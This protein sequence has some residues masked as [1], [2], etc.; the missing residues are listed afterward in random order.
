MSGTT[1]RRDRIVS[2][3]HTTALATRARTCRLTRRTATAL[4][5]D[6]AEVLRAVRERL[7]P[8]AAVAVAKEEMAGHVIVAKAK[9]VVEAGSATMV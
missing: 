7:A 9:E 2:S 4:Q 5:P 6:Q 3:Q 8:P 1:L